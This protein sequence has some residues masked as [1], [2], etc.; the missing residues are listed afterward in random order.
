[1][2]NVNHINVTEFE[3]IDNDMKD[4][5]IAQLETVYDPEFPVIDIRTLWLIYKV[6]QSITQDRI[7]VLM[8]FTTP[9]CPMWE[10][11]EEM[12]KNAI[13]DVYPMH[14]V[15]ISITFDPLWS[16]KMIKDEDL[17]RMFE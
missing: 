4:T 17:Q 3:H 8:T 10:M 2:S 9:A 14:E 11:I 7:S 5:L 6:S 16:P 15:E 1:M 12:V 13:L